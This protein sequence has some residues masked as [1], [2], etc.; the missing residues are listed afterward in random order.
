M[1]LND[2]S[3]QISAELILLLAS[4]I[5]IVLIALT[6]Y[7]EYLFDFSDEISNNELIN[8]NKEMDNLKKIIINGG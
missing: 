2:C 6:T 4:I 8:L 5:V 7:K 3:G 1:V